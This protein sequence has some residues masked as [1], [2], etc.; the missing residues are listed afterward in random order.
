MASG[1]THVHAH[2][3]P[4]IMS[5]VSRLTRMP[6]A[7][8][9]SLP[10]DLGLT[11]Q[12]RDLV[13]GMGGSSSYLRMLIEREAD[14][15][16]TALEA[17]PER[18]LAPLLLPPD[19]DADVAGALRAAKRRV[20]L[21]LAACDLGGVW[22]LEEVTGALTRFADMA[23]G[24]AFDVEVA[25]L[26]GRGKLPD[27]PATAA[28]AGIVVLA[29]GK[30]GAGELNYSSDIDLIV[31]FDAARVADTYED[32]RTAFQRITRNAAKM[33]GDATAEGYVFRTDLRLRPNPSVTPVCVPLDAAER[34]YESEGRTW[35]RAAYIKARA[36]AGD[37][38]AG[39][40]FLSRLTP[41]VWRRHLDFNAIRDAHDMRLAIRE[42]KG[43]AGPISAR[44]HDMKL[45]RGGIREIEFFAQTQ[46]L[47]SGGR[48]PDLRPAGTVPAL[49][50]LAAKGWVPDDVADRLTQD[51]RAHREV[52]HR[53][54][55]LRDAQ[56][57]QLPQGGEALDQ[58]ARLSGWADTEG[59][60]AEV[61][62][63]L[64]EVHGLIEGFFAPV[65]AKSVSVDLPPT[66][67]ETLGS[68]LALPA[69]RSRRA[70]EHF[71]SLRPDLVARIAQATQPADA[72]AQLD[73]FMRGLPAGVQLFAMFSSNRH[74]LDL[75]LDICT[76]APR[77][78]RH[79][80]SDTGVLDA[81]LSGQ[82]FDP[83]PGV[84]ALTADLAQALAG[85]DDFEAALVQTRRWQKELHFR[86][87]VL[88]LR[89]LADLEEV[90]AAYSAL[91][92]AVLRG[93]L[94]FVEA[95]V[96]RR[97]GRFT[98]QSVAILGMG[99]LGSAQMTA[100]SDLDLIVIYEAEGDMASGRQGL[101]PTQYFA[102][103][104][105]T[106]IT[107]LSSP[108]ADGALYEV[109]MRLRPSGRQGPVAVSVSGFDSYQ[110]TKA[111]TWEHLALTRAR[112][113]AGDPD[114]VARLEA[115]R[116]EVLAAPRS[117]EQVLGDV[118]DMRARLAAAKGA[119]AGPWEVK[120]RAGGMMD[121]DLAAQT[122]ALLAG[123]PARDPRAQL[124]H[125][126]DIGMLDPADAEALVA[127]QRLLSSLQQVQRLMVDGAFDPETLGRDAIARLCRVAEV[128]D[129]DALRGRLAEVCADADA[130]VSRILA[131]T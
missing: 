119:S 112:V 125:A 107:A 25:R 26:S 15:F 12:A 74:L 118:R 104:T 2:G 1:L 39:Q 16:C 64:T 120:D 101:A 9:P 94:P 100:T 24:A 45:G 123:A 103:L 22:S 57:H 14:W 76:T 124:T 129:L 110:K 63:R 78:A 116:A 10:D 75:L 6:L 73:R 40:E 70:V 67:T 29:M 30:M 54:Q 109:D 33:L 51:Y 41:F 96:E 128:P 130:R 82:F 95:E 91:A 79:L 19:P 5:L 36:C 106:L 23:V 35:E 97:Y 121:I 117:T 11:G 80:A 46:Q 53:I 8:D 27:A 72:L 84:E 65:D 47:I 131:G 17:E 87:G 55:M 113:V 34:Y 44:G 66:M 102:R 7:L 126:G 49:A 69:L 68:W 48:D 43:L 59:F 18:A 58:V 3:Q 111:W 88:L 77:L 81:V 108:M 61:Q 127:T 86:V 38:A 92:E 28:E 37:V 42:H 21:L 114:L 89:D 62:D 122:L 4:A 98:G 99:K 60:V 93:L 31:L 32:S 50:A 56:T 83:L 20:A 115:V 52:E 105:Q 71:E 90:E 13:T 85:C